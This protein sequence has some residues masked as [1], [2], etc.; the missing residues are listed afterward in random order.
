MKR[1]GSEEKTEM[2]KPARLGRKTA[3]KTKSNFQII[4]SEG[5]SATYARTKKL[6]NV[7]CC[8]G[9]VHHKGV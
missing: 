3:K 7:A 9:M 2:P 8:K 1:E 6:Y 4:F 5:E